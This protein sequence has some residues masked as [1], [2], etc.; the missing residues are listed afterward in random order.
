MRRATKV[1][2]P[3]RVSVRKTALSA[4]AAV[5]R[6]FPAWIEADESGVAFTAKATVVPR[7]RDALV[8][9][10]VARKSVSPKDS[11]DVRGAR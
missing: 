11:S 10:T 9:R 8:L 3:N 6:G 4:S 1:K 7:V 5:R 2:S